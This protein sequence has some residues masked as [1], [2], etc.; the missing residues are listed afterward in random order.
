MGRP[1][2]HELGLSV[3]PEAAAFASGIALVACLVA[4]MSSAQAQG[5]WSER[6]TRVH[7]RASADYRRWVWA[8]HDLELEPEQ[9]R[10]FDDIATQVGAIVRMLPERVASGGIRPQTVA[11]AARRLEALEADATFECTVVRRGEGQVELDV[12]RDPMAI[13]M[14]RDRAILRLGLRYAGVPRV[15]RAGYTIVSSFGLRGAIGG[16]ALEWL[17]VEALVAG[18]WLPGWGPAGSFGARAMATAPW[19]IARLGIGVAASVVFATDRIG[20]I[21]FSWMGLQVEVPAEL[22]FEMTETIGLTLTAGPIFTQA[23]QARPDER[24]INF[25]TELL[26]EVAL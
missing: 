6:A 25:S 9:R 10:C 18:G 24:A 23:G 2:D 4:P 16:F 12:S 3:R 7:A 26:V 8:R 20:Q 13:R 17:R 14:P 22:A 19:S 11:D 5:S 21:E 15:V 1:A